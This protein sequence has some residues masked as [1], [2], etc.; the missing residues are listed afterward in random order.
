MNL[1]VEIDVNLDLHDRSSILAVLHMAP[2]RAYTL[3][4]P[5]PEKKNKKP[6]RFPKP[7]AKRRGTET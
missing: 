4:T 1:L 2:S 5:K 3:Y 7:K 6:Q